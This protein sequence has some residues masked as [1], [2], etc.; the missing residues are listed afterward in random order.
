MLNGM[1]EGSGPSEESD[2]FR[3]KPLDK[4]YSIFKM[5]GP[6]SQFWLLESAPAF[7]RRLCQ[8]FTTA[9][10]AYESS[11]QKSE[12]S[13]PLRPF[14]NNTKTTISCDKLGNVSHCSSK[15]VYIKNNL[16]VWL[17]PHT[18][19]LLFYWIFVLCKKILIAQFCPFSTEKNPSM[20]YFYL[21]AER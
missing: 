18:T 19:S 12:S 2:G 7:V 6:A 5:T 11:I 17:R 20:F 4:A 15:S 21:P 9:R 14:V 1:Q 16:S 10:L 13:R 8:K 3:P